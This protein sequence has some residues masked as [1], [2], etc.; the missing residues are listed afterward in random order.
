MTVMTRRIIWWL[1]AGA[2]FVTV[3]ATPGCGRHER[4]MN[5]LSASTWGDAE[6]TTTDAPHPEQQPI[7]EAVRET[8]A[9]PAV[10]VFGEFDGVE[11]QVG[12]TNLP[13]ANFQQH[14][15][16]DEGFDSDVCVDTTGKWM[17]F[18]ST[19][20]S[21]HAKIYLQRVDGVSVTQLT[22][23]EA[24]DA[25]PVFSPDGKRIAFCS[26]RAG[27]WDIYV[28]DLDGK[29]VEQVTTGPAQD[30]HPSFSPDGNRLA[31][32][33]MSP[34]N[35]QWELWTVN[36]SSHEKKMIGL[37]LFPAWSPDKTTDRIAFQRAR[38]RGSRWF[39]L[40]TLE[41]SDGEARRM[42]EVAV[43]TNAAIIAPSWSPDGGK[44]A[45]ATIVEPAKVNK[46][47]PQGQQDI[48]VVDADGSNRH[49]VT[50]GLAANL[51]P[52]WAVDNRVYFVSDR[53][54]NECIW[55]VRVD[56]PTVADAP[57]TKKVDPF[58]DK[59]PAKGQDAVGATDT[60]DVGH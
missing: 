11:R 10:N 35:H 53:G 23:D 24:D 50:D 13:G 40:W 3:M 16:G 38:Q 51:T 60:R 30:M 25:F 21:E 29:A 33:S 37:G 6:N 42:T 43:S 26:T 54:G 20:H 15:F 12:Q 55:S 9:A 5:P 7:Q 1:A 19:R 48:W 27:N 52:F 47:K 57:D 14:T 34:R 45:F 8:P 46:G 39:S 4:A 41:L 18:A 59:K 22:N 32:C 17:V 36:L 56:A 31:F 28:M 44:L 2:T 58:S 49:R